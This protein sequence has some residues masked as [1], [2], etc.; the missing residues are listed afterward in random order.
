MGYIKTE[1]TEPGQEIR[2]EIR[3]KMLKAIVVSP[4]FYKNEQH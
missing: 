1:M 3:N 4:P 2:I